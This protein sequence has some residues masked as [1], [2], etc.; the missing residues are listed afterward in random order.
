MLE[1]LVRQ[2]FKNIKIFGESRIPFCPSGIWLYDS[3]LFG[4]VANYTALAFFK[5]N[6]RN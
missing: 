2:D 4:V 5:N 1:C 6:T 3:S